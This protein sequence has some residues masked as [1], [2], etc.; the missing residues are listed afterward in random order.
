M[1]GLSKDGFVWF[2]V[3]MCLTLCTSL[4]DDDQD[5]YMVTVINT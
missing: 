2:L 3:L 5:H 1:H 4:Q